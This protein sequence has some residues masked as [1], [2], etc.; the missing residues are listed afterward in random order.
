MT[1]EILILIFP[2]CECTNSTKEE[3]PKITKAIVSTIGVFPGDTG[4]V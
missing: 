3:E 4:N 1:S 2:R